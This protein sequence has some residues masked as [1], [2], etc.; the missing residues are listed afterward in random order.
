MA[1]YAKCIACSRYIDMNYRFLHLLSAH[2]PLALCFKDA[3]YTI[4]FETAQF[5]E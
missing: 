1:L 3:D 4:L 2:P 5:K